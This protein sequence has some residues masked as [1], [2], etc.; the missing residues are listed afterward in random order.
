MITAISGIRD[1]HPD[2]MSVVRKAVTALVLHVPESSPH[3]TLHFGGALGVDSVALQ[4]AFD[5]H[6]DAPVPTLLYVFVPFTLARQPRAARE[7]IERCAAMVIALDLPGS[8]SWAYLR[9]ND[10]M[11]AGADR[12]GAFTDGRLKGGTYY[13]MRKAHELGVP[14][15]RHLVQAR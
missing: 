9:R 11:L 1:L 12:L 10:R 2:S 6:D 8:A 3:H 13:T 15:E 14:T 5:C 4:A 7:V